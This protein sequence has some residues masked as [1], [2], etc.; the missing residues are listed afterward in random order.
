MPIKNPYIVHQN[1][2]SRS[3]SV[4]YRYLIAKKIH[5][6]EVANCTTSANADR[7]AELLNQ[8]GE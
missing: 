1:K 8:A 7:I 2:Y 6:K 4:L 3:Y 5:F